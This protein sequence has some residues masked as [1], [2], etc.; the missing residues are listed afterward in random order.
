M[1][2]KICTFAP[3]LAYYAKIPIYNPCFMFVRDVRMGTK[4]GR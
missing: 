4:N 3:K 1:C 2:K